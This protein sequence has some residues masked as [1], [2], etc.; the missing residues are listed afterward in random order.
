M[1]RAVLMPYLEIWRGTHRRELGPVNSLRFIGPY[2][3]ADQNQIAVHCG[4]VWKSAK[5][6]YTAL[7]VPT[8]SDLHL[9]GKGRP[10]TT[11]RYQRLKIAEGT[12]WDERQHR[13]VAWLDP[14]QEEWHMYETCSVHQV[15]VL[16][17]A[18]ALPDEPS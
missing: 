18:G 5:T 15:L 8:P 16:C 1:A 11:R 4:G 13:M 14:T 9:P 7:V 12:I 3:K 6:F 17:A 10:E 2:L